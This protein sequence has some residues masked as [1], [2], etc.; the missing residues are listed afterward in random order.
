MDI[1]YA[2]LHFTDKYLTKSAWREAEA[3]QCCDPEESVTEIQDGQLPLMF[4]FY[5]LLLQSLPNFQ[6]QIILGVWQNEECD[7]TGEGLCSSK[8]VLW[9]TVETPQMTEAKETW[10]VNA[11]P[12]PRLN[13]VL[14]GNAIKEIIRSTDKIRILTVGYEKY[15]TV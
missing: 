7:Q 9:K 15:C 3:T 12:D 6:S 11:V 2:A 1:E 10:Q 13:P 14:E 4:R 5:H 8:K